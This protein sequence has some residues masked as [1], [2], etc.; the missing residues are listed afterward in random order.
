MSPAVDVLLIV[1]AEQDET[2]FVSPALERPINRESVSILVSL[3]KVVKDER[4]FL[5][6]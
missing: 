6:G 3:M 1:H 2:P 5:K 4:R